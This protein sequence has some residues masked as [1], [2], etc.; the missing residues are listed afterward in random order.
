MDADGEFW[1]TIVDLFS[2]G[3]SVVEVFATPTDPW[4]WVGLIGD[5]ID[6]I[7]F[8]TGV[9]ELA[10][11]AKSVD[12][13]IDSIK[14][15]KATDFTEDVAE[16]VK[17]LDRSSGFTE[18]TTSLG[19]KI[20]EGYKATSEFKLEWKEYSGIKGIKPDY[21]DFDKKVIY[22][23]KPMNARSIRSGIRQLKKYNKALGGG[24]SMQLELY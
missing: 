22:E 17:S 7:P 24:F 10:R 1:D 9:G 15:T 21:V 13:V 14:I 4:V 5:A 3:V 12:R 23:L 8:V 19:R 20:H 11:S 18:S 6:L 2:L 16:M